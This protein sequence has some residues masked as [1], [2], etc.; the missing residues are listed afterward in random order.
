MSL[1]S[2]V[3]RFSGHPIWIVGSSPALDRLPDDWLEGKLTIGLNESFL[4]W[5]GRGAPTFIH[6]CEFEVF[7]W[8]KL[9]ACVEERLVVTDPLYPSYEPGMDDPPCIGFKAGGYRGPWI[10]LEDLDAALGG[11]ARHRYRAHG[12]CFHTAVMLA[13]LMGSREIRTVGIGDGEG[14]C[15]AVAAMKHETQQIPEER[16]EVQRA[17]QIEGTGWL[18][19]A[20][21][22]RG[23]NVN[24]SIGG[25]CHERLER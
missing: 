9:N 23:V 24:L 16:R 20:C 17:R 11:N 3:N 22:A 8:L 6:V 4:R 18:M 19:A 12:T 2:L 21:A 5:S 1:G 10:P 7:M 14:Y 25:G 13:V 15:K